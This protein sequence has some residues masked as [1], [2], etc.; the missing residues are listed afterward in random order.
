MKPGWTARPHAPGI[1]LVK[2]VCEPPL[3]KRTV[4]CLYMVRDNSRG[5]GVLCAM[6]A[7][8]EAWGPND[9][10]QIVWENVEEFLPST[11]GWYRLTV[12]DVDRF[13]L[14]PAVIRPLPP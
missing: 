2:A 5:T 14:K 7:W 6:F 13:W 3:E 1:Y 4:P 12:P 10:A 11:R 8:C 9:V